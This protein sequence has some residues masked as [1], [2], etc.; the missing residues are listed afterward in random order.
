MILD[1]EFVAQLEA[2]QERVKELEAKNKELEASVTSRALN[3]RKGRIKELEAENEKLKKA[4]MRCIESM[5][6][7][8]CLELEWLEEAAK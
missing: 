8:N 7:S 6:G 1:G 2:A 3:Y 5:R 4:A